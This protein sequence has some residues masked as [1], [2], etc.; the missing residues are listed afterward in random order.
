[1]HRTTKKNLRKAYPVPLQRTQHYS[2]SWAAAEASQIRFCFH[3]W[4][5]LMVFSNINY[6][7]TKPDDS[8]PSLYA[9][10]HTNVLYR[11]G[12][13]CLSVHSWD[14]SHIIFLLLVSHGLRQILCSN[15]TLN[16]QSLGVGLLSFLKNPL[17]LR[18]LLIP[19]PCKDCN[20]SR[21]FIVWQLEKQ[22]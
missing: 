3:L 14:G 5:G 22:L 4:K 15:L 20:H 7:F 1:M 18:K 13:F 17:T 19:K 12:L 10:T 9:G 21:I 11:T 6:L 16:A 2:L 8:L